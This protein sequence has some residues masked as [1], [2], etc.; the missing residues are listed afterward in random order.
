MY[1]T[2]MT[3]IHAKICRLVS[4]NTR[5]RVIVPMKITNASVVEFAM[6]RL[7]R[8]LS[9]RCVRATPTRSQC[10]LT[11]CHGWL[12]RA[13][14]SSRV[15]KLAGEHLR[16]ARIL[17]YFSIQVS[18]YLLHKQSSQAFRLIEISKQIDN[19]SP[20]RESFHRFP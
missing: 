15:H 14:L 4:A 10:T 17:V 6:K 2:V 3:R 7:A 1:I 16:R 13:W 5:A 20:S 11:I 8:R 9:Q 19:G 18:T 12:P